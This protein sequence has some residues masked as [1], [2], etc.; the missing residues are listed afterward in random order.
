MHNQLKQMLATFQKFPPQALC[1][2]GNARD[3]ANTFAGNLLDTPRAAEH[4]DCMM[5]DDA[6]AKSIGVDTIRAIASFTEITPTLAKRKV[7]VVHQSEKMTLAAQ[8][9]F[10]K[11]LEE[12]VI[13]TTFILVCE[14]VQGL[15]P[16]VRSR[17]QLLR[18]PDSGS[19]EIDAFPER[20]D[21]FDKLSAL[22]NQA[23]TLANVDKAL[24][25]HCPQQVLSGF[26]YALLERQAFSAIDLC[27][28]LR[29]K[30]TE[31]PNLNW[32]MQRQALLRQVVKHAS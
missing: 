25:K 27:I 18:V 24:Q 3:V 7:V 30:I 14:R 10:L 20:K 19:N 12:P 1:M 9:A 6:S 26:Y 21:A 31:N 4:P 32:D 17:C 11:T 16:T 5:I 23:E 22:L 29:K 13:Q 15:L 28:A 8:Q 2:I